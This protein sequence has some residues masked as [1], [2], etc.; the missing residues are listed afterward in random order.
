MT[1]DTIHTCE[2]FTVTE[3]SKVLPKIA[4]L[5]RFTH[6]QYSKSQRVEFPPPPPPPSP[7][8]VLKVQPSPPRT[9]PLYGPLRDSKSCKCLLKGVVYTNTPHQIRGARHPPWSPL[10][11]PL[12]RLIALIVKNLCWWQFHITELSFSCE[13]VKLCMQS[14]IVLCAVL[15]TYCLFQGR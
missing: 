5:A 15:S 1:A 6:D 10:S 2:T 12:G 13:T 14:C 3:L 11:T 4:E 8:H 7:R 9:E